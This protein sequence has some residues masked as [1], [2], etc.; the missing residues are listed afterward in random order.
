VNTELAGEGAGAYV[1][2]PNLDL[3]AKLG[4]IKYQIR[5]QAPLQPEE[6]ISRCL[7]FVNRSTI[8]DSG[9]FWSLDG[10]AEGITD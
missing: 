3:V 5:L 6:S 7:S 1:S 8:D 9:K 4:L 2:I 10:K